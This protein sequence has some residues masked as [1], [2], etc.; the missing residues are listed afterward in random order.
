MH[1][2]IPALSKWSLLL[3]NLF[4][5]Y[6]TALFSLLSPFLA[7]LFF[8]GQ[9][10]LIA[11]ILTY[12]IIPLGMIA[13]PLGSLVFGYIGDT[14]GRKKA[15]VISLTGMAIITVFMGFLPTYQHVGF[16]APIFLSIGRIFQNFFGAG[17][18][19]GGAI[20]LIEHTPE[21]HKD[22]TSS[23]YN[24]STVAGVLLASVGVS[25]LGAFNLVQEYWR[26]LYLLGFPTVFFAILIRMKI[27]LEA[28]L[29]NTSPS[30]SIKFMLTTCWT[31]R[32]ALI[33]I[34]IAAGFSYASYTMALVMINGFVPLV[35]SISKIEM[36]H[37]NTI[38]LAI[39]FLLLPLF[40][41]ISNRFSRE[42]MMIVSGALAMLSGVPLFWFLQG[43]SLFAV[44][45]IRLSLVI[46]GVWFSAPFHSW[47]Q[48]LVPSSYRYTVISFAYAIGSQLLGGPTAAISLWLYQKTGWI[49]SVAWYWM[50]LGLFASYLIAKQESLARKRQ[51]INLQQ[52]NSTQTGLSRASFSNLLQYKA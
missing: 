47:A 19:M 17:E 23:F 5:H 26:L 15:L 44:I 12:C 52:G 10:P 3:G 22:I 41:I 48:N 37:L 50:L 29:I 38:L 34:A 49:V 31:K 35:T 1:S 51:E 27:T 4:E 24:A 40:G 43:A 30:S 32:D 46:I 14:R 16:L 45:F 42:K 21:S 28:P 2:R 18:T 39:D 13:R 25:L 9:D 11:L 33:T 6:D 36:M 20:F 8:P 7:P